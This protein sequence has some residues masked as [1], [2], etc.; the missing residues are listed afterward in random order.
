MLGVR[1]LSEWALNKNGG[2]ENLEAIKFIQN[3]NFQVTS[4]YPGAMMIAEE[5]TA[6]PKVTGPIN[7]APSPLT[8]SLIRNDLAFGWYRHVG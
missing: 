5:S 7:S 2:R 3:V 4:Q 8:A 1:H 6:W